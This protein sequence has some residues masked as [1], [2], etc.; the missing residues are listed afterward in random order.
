MVQLRGSLTQTG[1]CLT[2]VALTDDME[3]AT[4]LGDVD[5]FLRVRRDAEVAVQNVRARREFGRR[6]VEYEAAGRN[7]IDAVGD[8]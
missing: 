1:P 3:T 7:D 4:R 2:E 8:R 5:D 6:S